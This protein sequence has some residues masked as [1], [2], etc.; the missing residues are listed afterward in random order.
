MVA[1]ERVSTSGASCPVTDAAGSIV[2]RRD[3]PGFSLTE[4][5]YAEGTSLA[6]HRHAHSYLTVVLSGSYIET[7]PAREFHWAEGAVHLLPAGASH[8]NRFETAVRLLRVKFEPEA[9]HGWSDA[10]AR[11]FSEPR[12][13]AGP[14]SAWLANRIQREFMAEDEIA[15]LAMEGVLLEIIAEG[16]RSSGDEHAPGA[17]A[18]L[19]RVR[20]L[21]HDGYA[22][23]PALA[24]LAGVAGV[25]PV[26]L[27]RQF[28]KHYRMTVGDY[29]RKRRVDHA[30][31]LLARSQ[32]SLAEIA[33]A[34]GFSDQSHFCSLFKK[35]AG[36][37]PAK[38]R[39]LASLASGS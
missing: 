4:A 18:W 10:H 14:L 5:V 1:C 24:M 23:T 35:H 29:I 38:F 16:A 39:K 8:E 9:I 32:L 15:P 2:R 21:L 28:H 3:I 36:M 27:S 33:S 22:E 13:I 26:H 19:R 25:H 20:D 11:F 17:P 37:T 7:H 12:E 30:S 31:E 34:C 6:R